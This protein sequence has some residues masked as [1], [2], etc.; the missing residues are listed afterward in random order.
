MNN[1]EHE[2]LSDEMTSED[3]PSRSI[4]VLP[5]LTKNMDRNPLSSHKKSNDVFLWDKKENDDSFSLLSDDSEDSDLIYNQISKVANL[6]MQRRRSKSTSNLEEVKEKRMNKSQNNLKKDIKMLLHKAIK[7]REESLSD[8]Q[9]SKGRKDSSSSLKRIRF[10][11]EPEIKII[12]ESSHEDNISK[13]INEDE[14][15]VTMGDISPA[16]P[17]F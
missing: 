14:R 15:V 3:I 10:S 4:K 6:S 2:N 16:V 5:G 7:I 17:P 13:D 12:D 8:S 1:F 9:S 11:D